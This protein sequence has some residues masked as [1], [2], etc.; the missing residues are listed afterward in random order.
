MMICASPC[1]AA[2]P[3]KDIIL[4]CTYQSSIN[5]KDGTV[6]NTV[7]AKV[8]TIKRSKGSQISILKDDSDIVYLGSISD[9][10]IYG[11]AVFQVGEVTVKESFKINRYSGQFE[12]PFLIGQSG[13]IHQGVCMVKQKKKY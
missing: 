1:L 3:I 7:G 8:L 13:L 4:E 6:G 5:L 2:D 9:A 12:N 11:E 10:Q